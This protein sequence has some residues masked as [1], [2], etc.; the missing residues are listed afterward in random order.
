MITYDIIK[1]TEKKHR[2][3]HHE[4]R[5]GD[6]SIKTIKYSGIRAGLCWPTITSPGYFCIFGE[7]WHKVGKDELRENRGKLHLLAEG[8]SDSLSLNDLFSKLTGAAQKLHCGDIHIKWDEESYSFEGAFWE[9]TRKHDIH[10]DT[11]HLY[12]APH[13]DNIILGISWVQEWLKAG[14]LD[15]PEQSIVYGQLKKISK[16]DLEDALEKKF[17]AVNGLRYAV[18]AFQEDPPHWTQ[19]PYYKVDNGRPYSWMAL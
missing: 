12:P 16:L 17:Y 10:S 7:E 11:G 8:E 3:I 6:G 9:Y 13:S 1:A 4:V 2:I 18:S 19:P 14:L 5:T 15:I